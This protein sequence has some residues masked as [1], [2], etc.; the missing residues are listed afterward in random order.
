AE[1]AEMELSKDGGL[2]DHIKKIVEAQNNKE[3]IALF[4]DLILKSF[5]VVSDDGRRFIKNEQL[6][7]EFVQTEA[8][9]ELFMELASDADAA[10]AFV[11][12]IMPL[13][14]TKPKLENKKQ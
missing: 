4:K 13:I 12:G 10:S 3:I 2:S 6:K 7:E 14:E 5:G 8:Y 9:V 11:N 1:V